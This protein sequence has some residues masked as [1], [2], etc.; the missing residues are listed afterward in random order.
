MARSFWQR[1]GLGRRTP[2]TRPQRRLTLE[3]LEGRDLPSVTWSAGVNLPSARAGLNAV[4]ETDNSIID[5]GGSG[6]GSSKLATV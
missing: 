5:L 4:V 2:S 3:R 6:G 1:I